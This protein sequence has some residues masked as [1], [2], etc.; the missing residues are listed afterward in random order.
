M[1]TLIYVLTYLNTSVELF[2]GYKYHLNNTMELF[3]G[4]K[5]HLNNTVEL[6]EGMG[7]I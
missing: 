5:Y 2:E 6:F 1:P 4:Y 3:E 7:T